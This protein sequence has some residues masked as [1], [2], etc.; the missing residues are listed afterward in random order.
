MATNDPTPSDFDPGDSLAE[1][2]VD[3][4]AHCQA[5][6]SP[7]GGYSGTIYDKHGNYYDHIME[8]DVTDRPLFCEPCYTELENNRRQQE[9][10]SLG[11]FA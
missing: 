6:F 2:A 4:C 8:T 10:A 11:D 9:N 5:E 7:N 1:N 3:Q